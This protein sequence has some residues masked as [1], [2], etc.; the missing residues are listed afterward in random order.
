MPR[1]ISETSTDYSRPF[2]PRAIRALNLAGRLGARFGWRPS[3]E[4]ED[5]LAAARKSTGLED[6]GGSDFERPLSV[7]IEAIES[8]ARLNTL[9]R[10]VQRK[11]ITSLLCNRLRAQAL[12]DEHPE[13]LA[14]ELPPVVVVVG[15][16]RTGTTL[17]QRLLAADP[18]TRALMSWEAANPAPLPGEQRGQGHRRVRASQQ[19]ERGLEY[20]AP[21]FFAIHPVETDAPEEEVMLLDLAFMSQAPEAMAHVPTY[22]GWL[23]EQD[24]RPAYEY[25]AKLLKLLQWQR[26]GR[27]WVLKT[28]HHLEHLDALFHAFPQAHVV[29]THRDPVRSVASF[30]SMVTHGRGIFT[31]HVDPEEV[32]RHWLRKT[33]RM[34]ERSAAVRA[35]LPPERFI[36]LPYPDLVRDPIAAVKHIYG[37]LAWPWTEALEATM[38]EHRDRN[39]RHKYGRH[40]YRLGDFGVTEQQLRER[41]STYIER[42]G[43]EPEQRRSEDP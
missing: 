18:D 25:L 1:H 41:L 19:A 26:P 8:E 14:Q 2:R 43:I 6:F 29:H 4:V 40:I 28:P 13:I 5:L 16:Q 38:R 3:L 27:R 20:L 36:D 42:H 10:L 39:R 17:L 31:D 24:H 21:D 35:G 15:L 22:A 9:G 34:L 7:L 30:F 32:G 33:E 11:R 23:E 12:F 37:R